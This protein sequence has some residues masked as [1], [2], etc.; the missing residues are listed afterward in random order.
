[1]SQASVLPADSARFAAGELTD[2]QVDAIF[3]SAVDD[4]WCF[5]DIDDAAMRAIFKRAAS[6]GPVTAEL[7]D[8]QLK[9]LWEYDREDGWCFHDF[10]YD[11]LAAIFKRAAEF[12]APE[13]STDATSTSIASVERFLESVRQAIAPEIFEAGQCHTLAGVLQELFDG[14]LV[15]IMRN[16]VTEEGKL[17]STT[18]SHMVCEIDGQCYDIDG[19]DADGRWCE[20]WSDE[21]DEDGLI[22]QF[23]FLKIPAC[24]LMAFI[25]KHSA[26][27]IDEAVIEQLQTVV[28][29]VMPEALAPAT[30]KAF[31][32]LR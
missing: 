17:F 13:Q 20:K 27:P 8:P 24:V 31:P 22:N 6:I 29:E 30:P 21:P 10:G 28:A 9:A 2:A 23:E 4:G 25:G 5:H 3:D 7:S 32:T 16:Q 15:A 26:P 18:Y 12:V 19:P 14:E 11:P 1:M